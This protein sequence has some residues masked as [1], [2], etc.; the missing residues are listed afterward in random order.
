LRVQKLI[1]NNPTRKW[2]A[3]LHLASKENEKE[4]KKT[5]LNAA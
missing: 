4:G 3:F 1:A 2:Y 5:A